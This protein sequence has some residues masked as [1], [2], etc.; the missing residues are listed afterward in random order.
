[1]RCNYQVRCKALTEGEVILYADQPI[2]FHLYDDNRSMAFITKDGKT[3]IVP[4]EYI[5]EIGTC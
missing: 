4:V 2:T 3:R 1:M 5:L